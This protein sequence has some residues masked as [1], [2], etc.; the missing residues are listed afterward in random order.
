MD[1]HDFIAQ[2]LV[3][4]TSLSPRVLEQA[5]SK[6]EE[7]GESVSNLLLNRGLLSQEQYDV[8][9]TASTTAPSSQSS[10]FLP[11][12]LGYEGIDRY[13]IL[14]ELG[15]GGMG[16]V[17]L[18]KVK[19]TGITVVIKTLIKVKNS[20]KEVERFH[21][22]GMALARLSH[23][24]IARVFD[25]RLSN[26][27]SNEHCHPYLVMEHVEGQTLGEYFAALRRA[28]GPLDPKHLKTLFSPLAKALIHCHENGIIHR[29]VKPGNILV[30]GG[31]RSDSPPRPVLIDFGL[32]KVDKENVRRSL[33][34][35]QQLTK[36]G[37][38]LGS[39]AFAAPEQLHGEVAKFG[40]ALDVWGF[41]ATLYWA[42]SGQLPYKAN[43]LYQLFTLSEKEN[44]K[45][46]RSHNPASPLW[47]DHLCS[48]CLQRDPTLRPSLAE[49][50]EIIEK[51]STPTSPRTKS[52]LKLAVLC[53]SLF[54]FASVLF[55]NRDKKAPTLELD[56][57][58]PF[59][60]KAVFQ[61]KGKIVDDSPGRLWIQGRDPKR[62][63]TSYSV[64]DD[65]TFQIAVDLNDGKN[66]YAIWAEDESG[67]F[68][69][70]QEL[71]LVRD[72]SA[73]T[74]SNLIYPKLTYERQ[75]KL[76]G[77]VNESVTLHLNQAVF[78][79]TQDLF[80]ET[81]QLSVGRNKIRVEVIDSAGNKSQKIIEITRRPVFHVVP[82]KQLKKQEYFFDS[83]A[84]AISK[85]PP[86]TRIHIYPGRYDCGLTIDKCLEI[87]GIGES[88]KVVLHSAN[89]P[90]AIRA[91]NVVLS[92][93]TIENVGTESQS[94][95]LQLLGDGSWVKSCNIYSKTRHGINVGYDNQIS[96]K[97]VRI[98]DCTLKNSGQAG[99][100]ANLKSSVSI[101][102]CNFEGN[103]SY[104]LLF[105]YQAK[106]K[107]TDCRFQ[108]NYLGVKVEL[109]A[110][111][112]IINS[113]FLSN[114]HE[115][116][117]IDSNSSAAV[118]NCRFINN[119]M[120]TK[121]NQL[122]NVRAAYNSRLTLAGCLIKGGAR[123]GVFSFESSHIELKNCTIQDS[124]S[125]GLSAVNESTI[126][127]KDCILKNNA[128]GDRHE[129]KGGKIMG[130]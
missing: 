118:K 86:L 62:K 74:I 6:A 122:P 47:L 31:F 10:G 22:E 78:E 72:T 65:G 21:R 49:V 127:L 119:G 68:S 56:V 66:S 4:Y 15:Q 85:A 52:A 75:V 7:N 84:K 54:L 41:A 71:S 23:P 1:S 38:L 17:Y 13:E 110:Q 70:A 43:G 57:V 33:E 89:K 130:Q 26:T 116:I 59:T 24:N 112:T 95:A 18:A 9:T 104:A 48:L 44:P 14:E 115:G 58:R 102:N 20:A 63:R 107:V 88:S 35:S 8:L 108:K 121:T 82:T 55:L 50:L 120:V 28:G 67:N 3:E 37:Q 106:G 42:A 83:L 126:I 123:D 100:I 12:F 45:P 19:E 69:Q 125:F 113:V 96:A 34:I 53:L 16:R 11:V 79:L 105:R 128:H 99:L 25:F 111:A 81:V 93:L 97:R 92:N 109:R 39:P 94:D 98:E 32:V 124:Q 117:A 46:L 61:L 114:V 36:S 129:F 30:D 51:E 64:N 91:P 76:K 103:Q 40:P 27:D 2:W 90:F 80:H 87:R 60:Q 73:P 5:I 101:S 77:Q 29:D